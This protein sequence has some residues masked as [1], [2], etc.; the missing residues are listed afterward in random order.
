METKE[1][2]L[3]NYDVKNVKKL[4]DLKVPAGWEGSQLVQS[5][6]VVGKEIVLLAYETFETESKFKKGKDKTGKVTCCHILASFL[7]LKKLIRFYLN[8][9]V[10]L[11]I[12]TKNKEKMPYVCTLQKVKKYWVLK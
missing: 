1:K 10:V 12:L 3:T 8:S 6:L 11:D 2:T 9:S 4:C 7:K 5:K